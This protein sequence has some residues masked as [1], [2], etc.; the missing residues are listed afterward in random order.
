MSIE[1]KNAHS[2][3]KVVAGMEHRSGKKPT[4]GD[5]SAGVA[6][7]GFSA[8]MN[9]MADAIP[10]EDL[11]MTDPL[12][13]GAS[14]SPEGNE[15]LAHMHK[16]L[17]AINS[18]ANALPMAPVLVGAAGLAAVTP[19]SDGLHGASAQAAIAVTAATAAWSATAARSGV[20]ATQ[21]A[22]TSMATS[23]L[24]AKRPDSS[25]GVLKATVEAQGNLS[26]LPATAATPATLAAQRHLQ[27]VVQAMDA[28]QMPTEKAETIEAR[29]GEVLSS[30][31]RSPL[32]QSFV[33]GSALN[34]SRELKATPTTV[35]LTAAQDAAQM[36]SMMTDAQGFMRP[37]ERLG[38]PL[39]TQS[40]SGLEGAFGNALMDKLGIDATYEVAPTVA[41]VADTQVAETVSYWVTHG[42]QS[43][44]LTL[45]GFG[46]EPVEVRI[47]LDGDQAQIDFWSN[48]AEV[49]QVL[50]G[51]SA[52][53]K[54]MLSSEGLQLMGMSV[55]TSSRER[56][57]SDVDQPKLSTI[58]QAKLSL[59]EPL[60]ATV[61]RS[62]NRAV[63][64]SLDLYV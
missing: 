27:P 17:A 20:Q 47:S 34:E 56:G 9:L 18:E 12:I 42:V 3:A 19:P 6:G 8:L 51:A 32:S 61:T 62:A 45:D 46:N 60:V 37:Q 43:A 63:G 21:G 57:Q 16:A 5:T 59:V 49:R 33:S 54:E 22:S 53:L 44:E 7:G 50:E 15:A 24:T 39:S 35:Q 29:G 2:S 58:R 55:G 26:P 4:A 30:H 13:A 38:K 31:K 41:V 52:Q 10:E 14:Q 1:A 28:P 11:K 64:Q 25:E 48:Q 23:V 36:V 40:G